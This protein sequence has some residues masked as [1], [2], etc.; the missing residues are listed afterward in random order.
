MTLTKKHRKERIAELRKL[1]NDYN[2]YYY[3]LDQPKVPDA[4]YDRLFRELQALETQYPDLITSDSPTQRIGSISARQISHALPMLSLDNAFIGEEVFNFDRRIHERLDLEGGEKIVY[5]CEPKIDGVAVSLIYEHGVLTQAATRGDGIVGEDILQNV[6]TIASMPLK[7][8]GDFF[9]TLLEVRGEVYMSLENFKKFNLDAKKSGQKIFVNPRN[10]AAGS[11]RQLDPK[12]TAARALDIFCYALGAFTGNNL[13]SSQ[14]GVLMMLKERGLKINPEIKVVKGIAACIDYYKAMSAKRDEL[15]YEIDG[16]VYKVNDFG[17]QKELGFVARAPRWAIAHKF[18]AQ[19]ELTEVV[20]I[21]FQVGRTG[22]LTPVARLQPVFVGGATISNATLHNIEEVIRKDIR[23]GDTVIIRR[24]GDVIPEV[25]SVVI[26]K[27]PKYT[28]IVVLPKFC[29]VCGSKVIKSENEVA[30]RCSGSLFCMAQLKESIKHFA[31]R[32]AL[33]IKGLGDELIDKL[34][35]AEIVKSVVDVYFLTQ[36]KL[37]TLKH[38]G[39]KSTQ[40]ILQAITRSKNTTL[41][42]FIYALGIRE[43][44]EVTAQ[45]LATYFGDLS[46]LMRASIDDLMAV[47]DIGPAVAAQIV[48]FFGEKR[49]CELVEKLLQVGINW[50]KEKLAV[51]KQLQGKIFVLTGT[52]VSMSRDEAKE[53]LVQLGAKVNESVSKKTTYVVIG[54]NP[55]AKLDSAKRLGIELIDES[56][57]LKL[58]GL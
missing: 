22:V 11:L 39:E 49:N 35:N 38:Q 30:A 58:V 18:P 34:V 55:G 45:S 46:K 41:A 21:E 6:R 25:V 42:K 1:L 17:Q 47:P 37:I 43:V 9:P 50:S 5:M 8:R 16:V 19:E 10:A 57:F 51:S 24:A 2:Y 14:S 28:Q 15:P 23:I 56:H 3:V 7:L 48:T 27:R 36:E 26:E 31:A 29:P 44:G 52:L 40:N 20:N 12:I 53:K 32:E 33:N 13:P 4:E 54:E